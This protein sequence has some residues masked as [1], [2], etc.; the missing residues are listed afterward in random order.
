MTKP[1]RPPNMSPP[2]S[3]RPLSTPSKR[4]VLTPFIDSYSHPVGRIPVERGS[5][6][7]VMKKVRGGTTPPRG[8]LPAICVAMTLVVT[9]LHFN[10]SGL[11]DFLLRKRDGQNAGFVG[12]FHML[13]IDGVRDGEVTDE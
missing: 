8:L 12:R 11:R 13:G 4:A 5:Q 10:G 2:R 9:D 3:N 6:K 1:L 7:V